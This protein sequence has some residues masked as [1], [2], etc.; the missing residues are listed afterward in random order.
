MRTDTGKDENMP[1]LG[2]RIMADDWCVA[3]DYSRPDG[4]MVEVLPLGPSREGSVSIMLTPLQARQLA[5]HLVVMAEDLHV[6]GG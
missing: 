4:I 6:F 5:R 3:T 1:K 2:A